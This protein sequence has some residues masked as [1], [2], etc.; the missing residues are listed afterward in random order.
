[1]TEMKEISDPSNR[2]N[3]CSSRNPI[4]KNKERNHFEIVIKQLAR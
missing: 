4:G 1:M 2:L 3:I